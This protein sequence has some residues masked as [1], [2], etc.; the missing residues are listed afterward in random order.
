MPAI[1]DFNKYG[2]MIENL[3]LLQTSPIAVKMLESEDDIPREAFR[4]K[5]D[6][7][8]H[9]AQC[10]A[11]A[12]SRRERQTVAMLKE[13][14][15]CWGSLI[16]Y[17]LVDPAPAAA[18]EVTRRQVEI[19]PHFERGKYIGIVSAP[20]KAA[21]FIPDMALVFS[22]TAQLRAM[23]M[24]IK[25]QEGKLVNSIFDPIDSCSYAV[26]PTI[27]TGEYRITLPDPGECARAFAGVDEI[28]LSVPG[29]KIE[30]LAKG[31]MAS[32]ERKMGYRRFGWEMCPDFPRPQFYKD[33]YKAWD[34]D[35][36]S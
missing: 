35:V 36:E 17:G 8:Y 25:Q 16:A 30:G 22:N 21:T 5:R 18:I 4:P 29:N 6:K 14:N 12:L 27:Q 9:L 11:F 2:E 7:G 23:L 13:D 15:W 26:V 24:V 3:L 33:L 20:L 34:L 19:L 28:I 10:Q 1:K 31:L 32:E